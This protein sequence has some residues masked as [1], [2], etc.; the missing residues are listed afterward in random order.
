MKIGNLP[1]C[2]MELC[3]GLKF[4]FRFHGRTCFVS[5]FREVIR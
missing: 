5:L 1:C 4:A 2:V 3:G